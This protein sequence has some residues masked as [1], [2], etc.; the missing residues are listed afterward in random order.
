MRKMLEYWSESSLKSSTSSRCKVVVCHNE[1]LS[2]ISSPGDSPIYSNAYDHFAILDRMS[3]RLRCK[4]FNWGVLK[5]HFP[6]AL[7]F[8]DI[9]SSVENC[10]KLKAY[11]VRGTWDRT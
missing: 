10:P 2:T 11:R 6:S 7:T 1:R 5:L 9:F 4:Y 3:P 8:Y